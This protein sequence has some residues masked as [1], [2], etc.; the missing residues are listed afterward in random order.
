LA[1]F[2]VLGVF[3]Y[4]ALL[5]RRSGVLAVAVA[6]VALA[7]LFYVFAGN[8]YPA[9]QR[10][11]FGVVCALAPVLAGVIVWRIQKKGAKSA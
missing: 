2:V 1:L 11:V 3:V 8:D 6:T 7:V 9:V 10:S 5:R 4:P